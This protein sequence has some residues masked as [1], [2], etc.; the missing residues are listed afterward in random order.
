[1]RRSSFR[2]I[3]IGT[4]TAAKDSG[5]QTQRTYTKAS[6]PYDSLISIVRYDVVG[7]YSMMVHADDVR[8]NIY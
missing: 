5:N 6:G 1:M 2:G 8:L 4:R 3:G 7:L